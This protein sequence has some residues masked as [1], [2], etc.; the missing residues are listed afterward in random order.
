M[1]AFDTKILA[2]LAGDATLTGEQLGEKVGLSASAA[3]RRMKALEER[4]DI[5]GYRAR[6]SPAARGN[7]STMF[8]H[9]TLTDQRQS[10]MM[11]FE[12]ALGRTAQVVGAWLISGQSDYLLKVDVREDDSYERVHRQI[13]SAL[14]GVHRLV[15]QFTIRTITDLQA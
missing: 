14:P 2:Q 13:L 5:L 1:D 12:A 15:T 11:D 10:T 7:P 8:V 6:L 4:G 9:V 3:Y